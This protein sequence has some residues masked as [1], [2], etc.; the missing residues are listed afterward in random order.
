ML[1][2]I[3]TSNGGGIKYGDILHF[4]DGVSAKKSRMYAKES[5]SATVKGD[6]MMVGFEV[7][8]SVTGKLLPKSGGLLLHSVAKLGNRGRP[9]WCSFLKASYSTK[10]VA[11]E[12]G[13]APL[14]NVPI[15]GGLGKTLRCRLL[16]RRVQ[17]PRNAPR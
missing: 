17:A 15:Q 13:D 8:V 3:K 5:L 6:F 14:F 12:A 2:E 16:D 1:T 11:C 10:K 7:P 9:P 4:S